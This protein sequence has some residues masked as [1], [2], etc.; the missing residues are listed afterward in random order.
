M[1]NSTFIAILTR[2]ALLWADSL[3]LPDAAIRQQK[4][5]YWA[6]HHDHLK[7]LGRK[8]GLFA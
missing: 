6:R 5:E 7:A 3:Y 1:T 4:A 8:S 2:V